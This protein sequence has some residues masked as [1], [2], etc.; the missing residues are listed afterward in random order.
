MFLLGA[1]PSEN[2]RSF[3]KIYKNNFLLT[4]SICSKLCAFS[5]PFWFFE[6]KYTFFSKIGYL[7]K[8]CVFWIYCGKSKV[9][10]VLKSIYEI[11]KLE[12]RSV[13]ISDF[14]RLF[15]DLQVYTTW[16]HWFCDCDATNRKWIV[17]DFCWLDRFC[18]SK[19]SKS[20]KAFSKKRRLKTKTT[21][22]SSLAWF[23]P[24]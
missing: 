6:V 13:K 5:F 4:A 12:R 3:S 24:K 21:S 20:R 2:G 9:K 15:F 14:A 17:F 11:Q 8:F 10:F 16:A 7:K 22:Y 23:L 18:D 19:Q 1:S